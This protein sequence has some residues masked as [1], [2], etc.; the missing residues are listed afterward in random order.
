MKS[1]LI[2]LAIAALVGGMLVLPLTHQ[3]AMAQAY[4]GIKALG[5]SGLAPATGTTTPMTGTNNDRGE[6]ILV[7]RGGRGGGGHGGGGRGGGRGFGGGH[8]GGGKAFAGGGH[9]GGHY[10]YRGGGHRGGHYA[11]RGGGHGYKG[12]HYAYRD[13]KHYRRYGKGHY[14][15]YRYGRWWYAPYVTYGYGYGYGS[16]AWLRRQALITGSQ[17]WWN[18]YYDCIY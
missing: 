16:C 2:A 6:V 9:R 18:R 10:A 8:H 12:R 13:G 5:S 7:G 14:R 1:N 11:Y 15:Y 4:A 17:Y 3:S